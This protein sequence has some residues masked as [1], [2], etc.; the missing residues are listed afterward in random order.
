[1]IHIR[2]LHHIKELAGIGAQRLDIAPLAFRINRIEG[3]ARFT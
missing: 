2:F 1:M 3:Q